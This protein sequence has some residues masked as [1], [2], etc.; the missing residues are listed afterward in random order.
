MKRILSAT[1]TTLTLSVLISA[2][3]GSSGGGAA[4]PPPP[5]PPPPPVTQNPGGLWFAQLVSSAAPDVFTSFEFNDS[6]G[7]TTGIAP[8]TANFSN[9]N[10]ETRMIPGFYI[11]GLNAWHILIGTS[12]TVTFETLPSTLTFFVR[13]PLAS[14]VGNIDI[15][16]ENGML[17][18]NVVLA[19]PDEP[20]RPY[21]EVNVVRM[22]DAQRRRELLFYEHT[23]NPITL[24]EKAALDFDKAVIY[25]SQR[26]EINNQL[27]LFATHLAERV[28]INRKADIF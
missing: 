21:G 6:A 17:I 28:Y 15:F 23:W 4:P 16:D 12:A 2:C 22:T 27:R 26:A 8:Y 11:S 18:L 20:Q 13:M 9:G 14:D 3:G 24:G 19:P 1:I 10:A 25:S 7:F 5:P